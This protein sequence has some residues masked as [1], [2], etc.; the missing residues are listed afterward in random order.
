[1]DKYCL[2][3]DYFSLLPDELLLKVITECTYKSIIRLHSTC[4]RFNKF[5]LPLLLEN[6]S[7][8]GFPRPNGKAKVHVIPKITLPSN[9]AILKALNYLID[10]DDVIYGDVIVSHEI[11]GKEE[12]KKE[13]KKEEKKE[14]MKYN[15]DVGQKGEKGLTGCIGA[16]GCVGAVGIQG[17]M[18]AMGAIGLQGLT[19]CTGA[20]GLRGPDPTWIFGN[21]ELFKFRDMPNIFRVLE[22]DIPVDYWYN[23]PK[24]NKILLDTNKNV[25]FD[26]NLVKNQCLENSKDGPILNWHNNKIH[27]TFNLRGIEYVIVY[28]AWKFGAWQTDINSFTE[29]LSQ[30]NLIKFKLND[31]LGQTYFDIDSTYPF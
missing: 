28:G 31:Y 18:G 5:N 3:M 7:K 22:S 24:D 17:S 8:I 10:N 9:E 20:T 2:M 11:A 21:C 6:K 12:Q 29:I 13:Q 4:K 1:M 27:T 15:L 26:H 25:W 16:T 14:E 23:L 30:D 19:G